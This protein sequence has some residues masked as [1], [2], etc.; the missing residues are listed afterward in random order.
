M[1]FSMFI[2]SLVHIIRLYIMIIIFNSL[3]DVINKGYNLTS[4]RNLFIY[5]F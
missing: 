4:V 3:V 1:Y 5:F 2:S